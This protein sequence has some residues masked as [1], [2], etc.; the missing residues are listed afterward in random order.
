VVSVPHYHYLALLNYL[1]SCRLQTDS[2]VPNI[3]YRTNLLANLVSQGDDLLLVSL[4]KLVVVYLDRAL[5]LY[6][7]GIDLNNKNGCATQ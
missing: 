7:E 6:C 2:A 5:A 3:A 1:H 4:T